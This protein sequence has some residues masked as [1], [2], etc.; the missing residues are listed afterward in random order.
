MCLLVEQAILHTCGMCG[1]CRMCGLEQAV[2]SCSMSKTKEKLGLQVCHSC[3]MSNQ[4]KSRVCK[5]V[6]RRKVTRKITLLGISSMSSIS[7]S[8]LHTKLNA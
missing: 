2:N 4:R 5:S 8:V 7:N 3:P 1:L 6:V